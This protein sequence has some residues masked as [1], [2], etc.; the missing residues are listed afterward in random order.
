MVFTPLP[1][2]FLSQVVLCHHILELV[3]K[4]RVLEGRKERRKEERGE[5]E[6]ET[7][8]KGK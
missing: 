3:C 4:S 7:K 6:K 2:V 1:V 5:R 8:R